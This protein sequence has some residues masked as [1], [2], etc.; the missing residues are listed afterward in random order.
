[1]IGAQKLR[2]AYERFES[3]S[4]ISDS[5]NGNGNFTY[6]VHDSCPG[7]ACSY[8]AQ[9]SYPLFNPENP[10]ELD[11]TFHVKRQMSYKLIRDVFQCL[12]ERINF[13]PDVSINYAAEG[14]G[15]RSLQR[16]LLKNAKELDEIV[17]CC[18]WNFREGNDSN[19]FNIVINSEKKQTWLYLRPRI[20][21]R[22]RIM[23]RAKDIMVNAKPLKID[24]ENQGLYIPKLRHGVGIELAQM[25]MRLHPDAQVKLDTNYVLSKR[26]LEAYSKI[27]VEDFLP[28]PGYIIYVLME[29]RTKK[30]TSGSTVKKEKQQLTQTIEDRKC[31][32][33]SKGNPEV[34][35]VTNSEDLR[36]SFDLMEDLYEIFK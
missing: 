23:N 27:K 28:P 24:N 22:T 26:E 15:V 9:F 4:C 3:L 13:H 1:M 33:R 8:G 16:S 32:I 36:P 5:I 14:K 6:H 35:F 21:L 10:K 31:T 20:P 34:N 7:R 19:P 17:D 25:L 18:A 12:S 2:D 11:F 29:D 30:T